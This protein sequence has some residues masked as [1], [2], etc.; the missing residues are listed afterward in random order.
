MKRAQQEVWQYY[1]VEVVD[2]QVS[3]WQ[4]CGFTSRSA[5]MWVW[6]TKEDLASVSTGPGVTSLV[7]QVCNPLSTRQVQPQRSWMLCLRS[8]Q[9]EPRSAV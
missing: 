6:F 4:K 5:R 9:V 3:C 2:N 1:N 7:L 8:L